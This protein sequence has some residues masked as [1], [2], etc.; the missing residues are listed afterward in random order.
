SRQGTKARG[1]M[2]LASTLIKPRTVDRE[3]SEDGPKHRVMDALA[4]AR[5]STVRAGALLLEIGVHL[6]LHHHF[7][8]GLEHR[9][10]L[11]E[12]EAECLGRQVIPFDTCDVL[13]R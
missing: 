4:P 9:F 12:R 11:R 13:D 2:R 3:R 5:L 7:L 8:Q 1:R 6:P 10:A